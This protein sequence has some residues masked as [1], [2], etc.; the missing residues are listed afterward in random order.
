MVLI[1]LFQIINQFKF[2]SHLLKMFF[3]SYLFECFSIHVG[4]FW[5]CSIAIIIGRICRQATWYRPTC[6]LIIV[7]IL[8]LYFEKISGA[9]CR[10]NLKEKLPSLSYRKGPAI[11]EHP[12]PAPHCHFKARRSAWTRRRTTTMWTFATN[13]WTRSFRKVPATMTTRVGRSIRCLRRQTVSQITSSR[14]AKSSTNIL[15]NSAKIKFYDI[16]LYT[17]KWI[18]TYLIPNHIVTNM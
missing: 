13:G 1:Y 3:K 10:A 11:P 15:L 12:S 2:C 18:V 16:F 6:Y 17:T 14:S 9:S 5:F 4:R 8:I 7:R